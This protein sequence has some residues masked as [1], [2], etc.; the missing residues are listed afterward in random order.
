MK[1]RLLSLAAAAALCL[2]ACASETFSDNEFLSRGVARS[3]DAS[4]TYNYA[5]CPSTTKLSLD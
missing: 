4:L 3:K 5:D 1:K 2:T